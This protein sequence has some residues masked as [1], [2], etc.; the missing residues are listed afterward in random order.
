MNGQY[1]NKMGKNIAF[2][3]LAILSPTS[4]NRGIGNYAFSQFKTMVERDKL[5]NYYFFNLVEE[6]S[7]GNQLENKSNFYEEYFFCGK[8]NFLYEN[9]SYNE[10]IGDIIK[11]FIKKN[12]IDIFYITSPMES[13]F[14]I[15][16]K[17]W[18][19]NVRVVATVYDIIPYV[20]KE[21]YFKFVDKKWYMKCVEM[22]RWVDKI[23]VISQSVKN[24]LINYLSFPE[25]QIEVIWGAID[26]KYR[27]ISICEY[28]KERILKRFGI[29]DKYIM[30][31]GGDDERKNI[32]GLIEAYSKL[33]NYVLEEYQLVIVCKLSKESKLRYH[34][35]ADKLGIDG[36]IVLTD[37]V[38]DEEMVELYNLAT[39]MAFPSKYEG[40]G[41]PVI[42]AWA[43]GTPVLT[44]NNSSLVQIAG[45]AGI[46]VDPYNIE[47]IANGLSK[48][49]EKESLDILLQ[50][51]KQRLSLFT[52]NKVAD[53]SIEI[54][55]EIQVKKIN[56]NINVE[57]AFF[58]PLP[59]KESGISDYSVDILN[60]ICQYF[61][62]D[63]Y[64]DD[65]YK[66]D[67]EL[68]SNVT[69][70]NHR[71]FENNVR[72]KNYHEIIYQMG[73]SDFHL[74]MYPYI[75]KYKGII[76][77]HDYNMNGIALH[78]SLY[79][80][81]NK[82]LYK[83]LLLEDYDKQIVNAYM[84]KVNDGSIYNNLYDLELNGFVTNYANKIIVHSDYAKEKLLKNKFDKDIAKIYSYVKISKLI[85]KEVFRE[86]YNLNK[87]DVVFASFG[88]IHETKRAI[89]I[90]KAFAQISKIYDNAIYIFVG[91]LNKSLKN[92]FE[93][94]TQESG[95][96]NKVRVTGYVDLSDFLEYV[97]CIDIGLNLRHPYNGENSA[98]V[99]RMLERQKCVI[100]ND[101]GS[102]SEI[103]DS[104]CYK[105][106]PASLMDEEQ[107]INEI[108]KAMQELL[109]NN[110]KR[111]EIEQNARK[112]TK[113]NLDIKKIGIQYREFIN[114]N[115]T[116]NLTERV[117]KKIAQETV[118]VPYS[119]SEIDML[120]KTLAYSR[121]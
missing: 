106:R 112:Y 20:M 77:L 50:K 62:V 79:L 67:C 35:L 44:S 30:C 118:L 99:I 69:I 91:K 55:N 59:P 47:D 13:S 16:H 14:P 29:I 43:C 42:E 34:N 100:V 76:V 4:K 19:Q 89:P 58:S 51:G 78:Y 10:I 90:L 6:Y 120:A 107:E 85:N 102:F 81:K 3:A 97:N 114:K 73:N 121:T 31:T 111:I 57:I 5:N 92:E 49:S 9:N 2:D 87:N 7:W 101:V 17:E 28:E 63:V 105:I 84:E 119:V 64:I 66:V 108:F 82:R 12:N 54:I 115:K 68:A 27:Q 72:Q 65:N 8:N 95:I 56:D 71:T 96:V 40:F 88:H 11:S 94:I 48:V 45:D 86:K 33:P 22:L 46:L 117:L 110:E 15:Y 25:E 53:K 116:I 1:E 60:E 70:Y 80:K 23:L 39:L 36:R 24:D 37:F 103:P 113:E 18:F 109:L 104:A 52:W 26:K 41:L 98:S 75:K 83:E 32:A 93:K 38:T 21:H 61:N 74:Y